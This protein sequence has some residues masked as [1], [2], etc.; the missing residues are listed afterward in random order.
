MTGPRPGEG[1]GVPGWNTP[2]PAANPR[3]RV[4]ASG[5]TLG[6]RA[7]GPLVR[8]TIRGL[9]VR[10]RSILVVV[11]AF[12]PLLPALLLRSGAVGTPDTIARV[13]FSSLTLPVVVPIVALI[14]G[15]GA[16]GGEIEEGTV[17]HLLARP[18]GRAWII[19]AKVIVAAGASAVL[20]AASTLASTLVVAGLD[21]LSLLLALAV[22]AAIGAATYA[23][24]FVA[25]SA[26]TTRAL[27]GGLGYVL[28]WEVIIT[29]LFPGTRLLSIRVYAE[30]IAAGLAG[31]D[32][33]DLGTD[34]GIVQ[35]VLLVV[36]VVILALRL[37]TVRLRRH[38]ISDGG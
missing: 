36:V 24:A 20:A 22:G 18:V 1:G 28:V 26:W 3:P 37:A 10:R 29:S 4:R 31:T 35:A 5:P 23:T 9:V 14:L 32:A 12:A 13:L 7:L 8:Q 6:R 11:L 15:T 38:E 17:V 19:L 2:T 25:L 33:G 34:V 16:L 21:S 27:V 30:G